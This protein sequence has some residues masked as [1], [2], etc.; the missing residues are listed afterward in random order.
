MCVI[1][2]TPVYYITMNGMRCRCVMTFHRQ[3]K[4]YLFKLVNPLS[5][6]PMDFEL[7][8]VKIQCEL[9]FETDLNLLNEFVLTHHR[10]S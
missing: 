8:T 10:V 6:P 7:W 1:T 9:E 3:L 4:T 5:D 2:Y